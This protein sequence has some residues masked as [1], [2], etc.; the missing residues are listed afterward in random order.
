MSALGKPSGSLILR[1]L[2]MRILAEA[3]NQQKGWLLTGQ[4]QTKRLP[5][6]P[7]FQIYESFSKG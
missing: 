3:A 7:N 4:Y 5:L 2:E 6:W 1:G